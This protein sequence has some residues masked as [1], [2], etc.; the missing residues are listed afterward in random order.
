MAVRDMGFLRGLGTTICG[1]LLFLALTVFSAAFLL[2]GTVLNT[3]FMN[4]QIDKLDISSIAHDAINTQIQEELPPNSDF[5]NGVVLNFFD[6]EVPQ[7]KTQL[8]NG[9][10]EAYDYFLQ[11]TDTLS[12]TISL[13]EIKQNLKD[14]IWQTAVDYLKTKLA[15]MSGTQADSYVGDIAA[16]IPQDLLP[17]ELLALP[18]SLRTQI[19]KQYLLSLGGKGVFSSLSFG[20]SFV[21]E[22][23]LKAAVEQYFTDNIKDIKDTYTIDESTIDSTTM[24]SLRD[25]R[26]G[27]SYFKAW[28]VWLIIIMVIL[29]GLI[30]LINWKNLRGSMRALGMDLLIFGILDLAGVLLVLYLRP[31]KFIFENTDVSVPVQNWI[32]GL[33]T[34]VT[35][36]MMAFSIGVLIVGIVFMAGSFFIKRP[37]A[38]A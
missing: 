25:I 22:P 12:V 1:I 6:K 4:S 11:K 17:P 38:K 32:H 37:E 26:T 35:S 21:I 31:E 18:S 33:I 16:Q 23:Q 9:I 7:I 28:Y 3:G 30:F 29:A 2:N 13:A 36:I 34:D 27:I 14:N 24:Q 5:I 20:L 10:N 19:E 15:G 8:H